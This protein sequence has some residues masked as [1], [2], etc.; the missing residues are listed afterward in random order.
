MPIAIEIENSSCRRR[1]I[2]FRKVV[3]DSF[4]LRQFHSFNMVDC[5]IFLYAENSKIP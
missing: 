5:F 4:K 2:L 3:E 1:Y